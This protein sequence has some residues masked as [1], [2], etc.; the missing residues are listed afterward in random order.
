MRN[1][2]AWSLTSWRSRARSRSRAARLAGAGAFCLVAAL[3][4]SAAQAPSPPAIAEPRT[5]AV[6]AN[7]DVPVNGVNVDEL[8]RLF[9]LHKN[10]WKPGHAVHP[11]LPG[12][13]QPARTFLLS[14]V[15]QTSE[16]DLRRL[17]LEKVY[18]GEV[19]RPSKVAGTDAEA[20]VLVATQKGGITVVTS[21][22]KLPT[23]TKVLRVD[24]KL[25]G[26]PG[27]ALSQP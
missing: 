3:S 26:E 19:D 27:Y 17:I 13:G 22:A 14:H 6:V 24:G 8:K 1:A 25:P 10:F 2:A 18:R 15:C 20:V 21:P 9:L 23:G 4:G 16:G 11:I 5:F 7:D 12:T